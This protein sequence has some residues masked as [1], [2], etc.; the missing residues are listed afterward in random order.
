MSLAR[1]TSVAL[2]ATLLWLTAVPV[3]AATSVADI[4]LETR[5]G[6]LDDGEWTA[7]VDATTEA[8]GSSPALFPQPDLRLDGSRLDVHSGHE[9]LT[10]GEGACLEDGSDWSA[11]YD[12]GFLQAGA[13]RMLAEAPT[14]PG[15]ESSVTI[16]WHPAETRLRTLLEFSGPFDIPSGR[17]WIDDVLAVDDAT[18]TVVASAERGLETSPFAESA[19]GRF[20][21]HLPAG[22]AGEQ[23]VTLVPSRVVLD[24]GG[25]LH[26]VPVQVTVLDDAIVVSGALARTE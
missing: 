9:D 14:T 12:R 24:G 18:G 21:D 20:Y 6:A 3:A 15:I 17:C 1:A 13:E 4:C 22:G 19:C 8:V 2:A 11:R 25:S 26:L 23:A 10:P 7:L 16:E 5:P